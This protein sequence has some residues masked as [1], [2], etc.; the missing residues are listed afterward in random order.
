MTPSL[1]NED[2]ITANR[3]YF[4]RNATIYDRDESCMVDARAQRI[5]DDHLREILARL[6]ERF[7]GVP[8]R[9]LDAGGGSGNVSLKLNALGLATELVDVSQ[10]MINLYLSKAPAEL[11]DEIRTACS[12]LETFFSTSTTRYH[13]ICFSS[14]LHHLLDYRAILTLAEEH[15]VPGG[16][17]Y[18]IHDPSPSSRFWNRV[19][20][21]DYHLST[22]QHLSAYIRRRLGFKPR[23]SEH[24]A[25]AADETTAEPH[26]GP[27]IDDVAL[28][29]FLSGL[30]LR[31][32][33]HQRY[34]TARTLPATLLFRLAG[35]ARGFSFAV[36][37]T[38]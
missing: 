6:R 36:E 37:K 31:I 19:E 10:E 5:V 11:R 24:A 25:A 3:E 23:P 9:I 13:L 2:V 12:D 32:V 28:R 18:T 35:H 16:M 1:R 22:F 29:D 27:G 30:G 7:P 21:A 4:N 34:K 14:V 38:A 20:M 15:L 26:V 17:I 33:W 8:L